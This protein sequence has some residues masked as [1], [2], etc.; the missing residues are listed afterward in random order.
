MAPINCL[1]NGHR[2]YS[3]HD[4]SILHFLSC[5]KHLEMSIADIK[6]LTALVYAGDETIPERLELLK[7]H[8]QLVLE[9]MERVQE[10]LDHV[11]KKI[12]YYTE[13]IIE[14]PVL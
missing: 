10:S 6:E 1:E 12:G 8:K 3:E 4:L 11:D 7:K 13:M 2:K 5:L 9:R 14:D